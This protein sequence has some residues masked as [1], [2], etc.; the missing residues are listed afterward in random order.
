MFVGHEGQMEGTAVRSLWPLHAV[1]DPACGDQRGLRQGPDHLFRTQP[2]G[3]AP[4]RTQR[5]KR[6]CALVSDDGSPTGQVAWIE[7]VIVHKPGPLSDY[8]DAD[9]AAYASV[10]RRGIEEVGK[11]V[12]GVVV[13]P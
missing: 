13:K 10:F 3:A 5:G 8:P 4:E 11:S 12:K 9:I 6:A 7:Q 1:S 2:R